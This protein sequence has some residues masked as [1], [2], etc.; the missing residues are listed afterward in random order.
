MSD[1][2]SL[3]NKILLLGMCTII[4][5][6]SPHQVSAKELSV[7]PA[8]MLLI[9]NENQ[10][11]CTYLKISSKDSPQ[12][13]LIQ[14]ESKIQSEKLLLIYPKKIELDNQTTLPICILAKKAGF[15]K[16]VLAI[17]SND[18]LIT[19]GV[20]MNILVNPSKN[21]LITKKFQEL[22]LFPFA[23]TALNLEA[24][25][26]IMLLKLK[27]VL[28]KTRVNPRLKVEKFFDDF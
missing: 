23:L 3:L 14:E 27:S 22:S 19:L 15:Y 6:L 8:K 4:L 25:L 20:K 24:L 9:M 13:I 28:T 26:L 10:E 7:L 12:E 1:F 2:S 18:Q 21:N 16:I 17:S 11:N 5:S